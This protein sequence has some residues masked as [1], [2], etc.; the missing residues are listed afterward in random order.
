MVEIRLAKSSDLTVLDQMMYDLHEEHHVACPEHFKSAYDVMQEKRIADYLELP[1]GLVF[2]AAS[3]EKVI[4]FVSG[5]FSELVS[6]VSQNVLMGSIDEFY[7]LP[8]YRQQG[9]GSRLLQRIEKEFDDYGVQQLFVE[10]W[11][12]NQTAIKLYQ[13]LGFCHHIHWLRKGIR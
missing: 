6:A 2:V 7:V 10:V 12:F 9:I 8:Q 11:D 1:E 4:G 3:R 13:K 5:H